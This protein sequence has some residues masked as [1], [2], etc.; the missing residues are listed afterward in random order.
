MGRKLL[1]L[2][3][4]PSERARQLIKDRFSDESIEIIEA[5]NGG[6]AWN[7]CRNS[8]PDVVITE[9]ALSK[10]SGFELSKAIHDFSVLER[11]A[12]FSPLVVAFSHFDDE[13]TRYWALQQGFHTLISK[14]IPQGYEEL[15]EVIKAHIEKLRKEDR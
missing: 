12:N 15:G 10:M 5:D 9:I 7:I 11:L 3:V 14:S 8:F 1:L 6:M 4:D 2:L 13:F